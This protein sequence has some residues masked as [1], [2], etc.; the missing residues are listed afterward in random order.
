MLNSQPFWP[1]TSTIAL[2]HLTI[3]VEALAGVL[4]ILGIATRQVALA[5]LPILLGA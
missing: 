4:L 2:A 1:C 5:T 3:G